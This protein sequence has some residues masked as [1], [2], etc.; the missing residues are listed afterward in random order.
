MYTH[1]HMYMYT[2]I[3]I[4]IYTHTH[5]FLDE[6]FPRAPGLRSLDEDVAASLPT[7]FLPAPREPTKHRQELPKC[8][9]GE[10]V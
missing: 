9:L 3:Y 5:I 4:Y 6:S 2:Y 10:D 1:M 7:G 8:V